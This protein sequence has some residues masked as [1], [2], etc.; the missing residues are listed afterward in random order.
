[1]QIDYTVSTDKDYDDAIRAVV[2]SAED[3][4]F[5]VQFIHDVAATLR[6]KGFERDPVSIVEMC[7]AK[8][9]HDA[10]AADIKV[11]LMLPCPVMVYE[12]AGRVWISTM[13]PSLISGFFPEADIDAVAQEVEVRMISILDAAAG[14]A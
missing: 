7:N 9:A 12:Q 6:E 14:A 1:M 11:G 5:R 2:Q 10:L 4:G 8:F 3:H 13:R